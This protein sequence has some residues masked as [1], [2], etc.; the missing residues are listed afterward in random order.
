MIVYVLVPSAVYD[1]GVLGVYETKEQAEEAARLVYEQSDG[2]H[3]MYIKPRTIG[4]TYHDP[5]F[6][7]SNGYHRRNNINRRYGPITTED[8][9]PEWDR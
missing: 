8:L 2:H 3:V 6:V 9:P 5:S 7:L 1:H 4:T